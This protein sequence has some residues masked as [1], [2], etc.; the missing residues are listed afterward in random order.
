MTIYSNH[1]TWTP[2]SIF[3]GCIGPMG[4]KAEFANAGARRGDQRYETISA[5]ILHGPLS[6]PTPAF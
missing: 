2:L 4:H 3:T 6:Q 1:S 5:V